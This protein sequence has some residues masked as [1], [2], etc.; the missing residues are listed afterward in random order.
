MFWKMDSELH[1]DA[2]LAECILF[3]EGFYTSPKPN[4]TSP[5]LHIIK[6]G[7]KAVRVCKKAFLGVFGLHRSG[8]WRVEEL[9]R[10]MVRT[11]EELRMAAPSRRRKPGPPFV[12]KRESAGDGGEGAPEDQYDFPEGTSPPARGRVTRRSLQ[13]AGGGD[14]AQ[15][16]GKTAGKGKMSNRGVVPGGR[17]LQHTAN[18]RIATATKQE[19]DDE[20]MEEDANENEAP[21]QTEAAVDGHAGEEENR[22]PHA[23]FTDPPDPRAKAAA[24]ATQQNTGIRARKSQREAKYMDMMNKVEHVEQHISVFVTGPLEDYKGKYSGEEDLVNWS[25]DDIRHWYNHYVQKYCVEQDY[26]AVSFELYRKLFKKATGSEGDLGEDELELVGYDYQM[27]PNRLRIGEA[28]DPDPGST[29]QAVRTTRAAGARGRTVREQ[30][31]EEE[32]EE[33]V[34]EGEVPG[35]GEE[36]DAAQGDEGDI[37]GEE[38]AGQPVMLV[39]NK[40]SLVPGV[41]LIPQNNEMV[42]VIEQPLEDGGRQ[43]EQPAQTQHAQFV[44]QPPEGFQV[45][46]ARQMEVYPVVTTVQGATQIVYT[47]T[48]VTHQSIE[49]TTTAAAEDQIDTAHAEESGLMPPAPTHAVAVAEQNGGQPGEEIESYVTAA[50]ALQ[51]LSEAGQEHAQQEAEEEQAVQHEEAAA[52]TP[53]QPEEEKGEEKQEEAMEQEP[54]VV[55][56]EAEPTHEPMEEEEEEAPPVLELEQV[57]PAPPATETEAPA[58]VEAQS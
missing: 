58:A 25:E 14:S 39:D 28:P 43:G 11:K 51:K 16:R 6:R 22:D 46:E 24:A 30:E 57:E 31:E 12:S 36:R 10:E 20:E 3:D 35:E 52:A 4:Q 33:I 38:P 44:E 27:D 48:T 23:L 47:P 42:H 26:D 17:F 2:Y 15:K 37:V 8:R 54:P 29:A 56:E 5:V 7:N 55:T 50:H 32:D 53:E 9:E 13:K 21:E 18:T 34:Y 19:P 41:E 1:R 45:V 40:N 49:P